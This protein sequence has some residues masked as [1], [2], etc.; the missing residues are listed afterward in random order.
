MAS[1]KAYEGRSTTEIR[2]YLNSLKKVPNWERRNVKEETTPVFGKQFTIEDLHIFEE[3]NIQIGNHSHTH[4]MFNKCD[5]KEIISEPN[6]S[7][8]CFDDWNLCGFKYFA[9]PNTNFSLGDRN[10]LKEYSIKLAF[11]F[12]HMINDHQL[13]SF[14]TAR[15]STN[16]YI[17]MDEFRAKVSGVY[18][19]YPSNCKF[20]TN[21]GVS[22]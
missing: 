4:P 18:F 6:N 12:E 13:N 1:E 2:S 10:F 7:K 11:R 19:I 15:I 5:A 3:A 21:L 14:R 20:K 8:S 17:G 16:S 22:S 9:Y